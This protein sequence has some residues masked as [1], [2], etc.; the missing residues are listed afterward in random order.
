MSDFPYNP[1]PVVVTP[2]RVMLNLQAENDIV[3][4]VHVAIGAASMCWE[5]V[6]SAGEFKTEM[7]ADI[8]SQ[9][10]RR[11]QAELERRTPT[12]HPI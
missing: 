3:A 1:P 6:Y 8:A 7:A 12:H 10:V 2:S 4:A 9:L 5:D 11:I